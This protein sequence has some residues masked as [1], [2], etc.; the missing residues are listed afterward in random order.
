[1]TVVVR[2]EILSSL[3]ALHADVQRQVASL[4]RYRA[5]KVIDQ[6]IADFP[7]LDDL[8]RALADIRARVQAQLDDNRAYRALL[9]IERIVPELSDA[10]A[11]LDPVPSTPAA[12]DAAETFSEVSVIAEPVSA[13]ADQPGS[14]TAD[15]A[16]TGAGDVVDMA[17]ASAQPVVAADATV[18]VDRGEDGARGAEPVTEPQTQPETHG[19]PATDTRAVPSLADSVAQLLAQS[20]APPPRHDPPAPPPFHERSDMGASPHAERAA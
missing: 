1:M 5:L 10:L 3:N 18:T 12:P 8:T 7:A 20:A 4:D 14:N 11:L 6:T 15:A 9:A 2:P 17:Y 16:E 19:E 13:E